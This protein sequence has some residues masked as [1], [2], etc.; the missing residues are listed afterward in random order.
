MSAINEL[1]DVLSSKGIK[2]GVNA[3]GGLRIRGDKKHLDDLLIEDIR[4][5]KE[6]LVAIL[7]TG[8]PFALLTDEERARLAEQDTPLEFGHTLADQIGGQLAAGFVLTGFYEDIDPDTI[9]GRHIPSYL[10]TKAV[11]PRS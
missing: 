3:D 4:Q 7:Q 5:H 6:Q 8:L 10:A 1:L 2:L 9:L 11:K